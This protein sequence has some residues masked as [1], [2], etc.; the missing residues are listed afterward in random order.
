LGGLK[1]KPLDIFSSRYS[2]PR[3]YPGFTFVEILLVLVV[4]VVITSI[5]IPN[6]SKSYNTLLLQTTVNDIAYLMRYAQSRAIIKK[7]TVRFIF[8]DHTMSYRIYQQGTDTESPSGYNPIRGRWG[9]TFNIPEGITVETTRPAIN[10]YPDG[11]IKKGRIN[12]CHKS[13]CMLISTEERRG[14]V[15][16]FKL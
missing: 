6:F 14:R 3:D 7:K 11:Q 5:S 9:R 15:Q 2:R 8:G 16:I 1:I 4:L 12:V 13:K 10:F